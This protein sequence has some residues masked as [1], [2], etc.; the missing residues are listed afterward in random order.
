MSI[1][2]PNLDWDFDVL[3]LS[4][5]AHIGFGKLESQ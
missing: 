4:N 1:Q 3:A 2:I 5:L